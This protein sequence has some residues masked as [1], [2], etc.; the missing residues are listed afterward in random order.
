M[1]AMDLGY[2]PPVYALE[3]EMSPKRPEYPKQAITAYA[4]FSSVASPEYGVGYEIEFS[5]QW[6][7]GVSVTHA[8]GLSA[9]VQVRHT[10]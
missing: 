7:A 5:R 3:A 9:R 10:F 2:V 6:S 4:Q 1:Y 8:D